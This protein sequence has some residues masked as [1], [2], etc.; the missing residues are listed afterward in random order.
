GCSA[1]RA[2]ALVPPCVRAG[3]C[4]TMAA[5]P[6]ASRRAATPAVQCIRRAA[7]PFL[8]LTTAARHAARCMA[9]H[10]PSDDDDSAL[11]RLG[12]RTICLERSVVADHDGSRRML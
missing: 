10:P 8:R 7:G 12:R 5:L 1:Q 6:G 3:G 4:L 2:L 11:P 9:A